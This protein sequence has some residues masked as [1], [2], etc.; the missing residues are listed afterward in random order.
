M[1]PGILTKKRVHSQRTA[2]QLNAG[3]LA[4]DVDFFQTD[5]LLCSNGCFFLNGLPQPLKQVMNFFKWITSAV[6]TNE[7]WFRTDEDC[8]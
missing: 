4:V 3:D 7:D 6:Q 2:Q 1:I 5:I 8:F